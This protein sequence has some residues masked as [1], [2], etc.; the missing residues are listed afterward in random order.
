MDI[1]S[2]LIVFIVGCFI[3]VVF[4]SIYIHISCIPEKRAMQNAK[5]PAH[6]EEAA[7]MRKDFEEASRALQ[8]SND[9]L[10]AIQRLQ[11]IQDK[12]IEL[13]RE[14]RKCI[15]AKAASLKPKDLF[16]WVEEGNAR[17]LVCKKGGEYEIRQDS[18]ATCALVEEG[19]RLSPTFRLL[20]TGTVVPIYAPIKGVY[21]WIYGKEQSSKELMQEG[22]S[23]LKVD[24]SDEAY[25][26]HTELVNKAHAEREARMLAWE[27]EE[28]ARKIKERQRRREL[29][30]LVT[31]ELIDNGELFD[32]QPKRP[33]IPREVVDAVWR[34]DG[35][36]CVYCGSTENLQLDHIIPFSKGGATTVENLQLLCAECNRKKSNHI[37]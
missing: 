5:L 31:K 17:Y 6:D 13:A 15:M 37:G 8:R 29:E 20:E 27:K 21:I 3:F 36:R 18:S 19:R 14:E 12:Q 25:A 22:I 10:A 33:P 4:V 7:K 35:G 2:D 28:I 11:S 23:V 34:R 24:C 16:G 9:R 30:K 1:L 32:E 26:L